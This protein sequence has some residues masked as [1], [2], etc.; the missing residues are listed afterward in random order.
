MSPRT[1]LLALVL[2]AWVGLVLATSQRAEPPLGLSALALMAAWLTTFF[3][4]AWGGGGLLWQVILRRRP[5]GTD[6]ALV[7]L[8]LGTASLGVA[9]AALGAAHALRPLALVIVLGVC[10]SIGALDLWRG[11]RPSLAAMR[12]PAVTAVPIAI[13]AG[14]WSMNLLSVTVDSAFYDQLHYHL[15]FPT[16]WLRAGHLLTFPR[17]D[18]SF[19][20]AGIG[21]L[22]VYALSVLGPPAAQA[23]HW[24]LGALAVFGAARLALRLAGPSAAWWTAAILSATPVLMW[25]STLAGADLGVAAYAAAGWLALMLGLESEERDRPA[26]WLLAGAAAGLAAGAKL[27]ALV[28]VGAP[29][30]I[31]LAIAPGTWKRRAVRL[32][33]WSL[34]AALLLGPWLLRNLW[35]TGNPVH[36]FLPTLFAHGSDLAAQVSNAQA[37]GT[38]RFMSDPLRVLTLGALGP[39]DGAV[40]PLHLLLAPLAIWCGVRSRGLGRL[41]LIGSALGVLGWALGPPTARYLLPALLPLAALA[42][43]GIARGLELAPGRARVALVAATAAV[44]AWSMLGGVDRENLVRAGIALGREQRD[45]VL[46]KWVSYWPAVRAVNELPSDSRVLLVA[47]SRS[48]YF[49]RDVV[50]EDPYR[51]PLL[52][53]LAASSASANDVA[54]ELRNRGVTHVLINGIEA[55]RLAA[56]NGRPDYFG[57]LTPDARERLERFQRDHLNVVWSEGPLLLLALEGRDPAT[58]SIPR[59]GKP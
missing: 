47:E 16:Q 57:D 13:V 43:A 46:T 17:S 33:A 7:A 20:P 23:L 28:T 45:A 35:V 36:P 37:Q 34:G 29:L 25:L 15:A 41:L 6:E 11:P 24:A 31:A 32:L 22:Y 59:I 42:G 2:L 53:E 51:P 14:A 49:E 26:W 38:I 19:Y 18:F 40:G 10:A 12:L 21:L 27:L 48:L 44:C 3:L 5:H 50:F 54:S 4:A 30:F 9:A 1:G 8:V 55:R 56:L 39:Q 58:A 52:S